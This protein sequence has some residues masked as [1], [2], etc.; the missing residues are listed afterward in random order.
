MIEFVTMLNARFAEAAP[1]AGEPEE[2]AGATGNRPF[3][4]LISEV[5]AVVAA[6]A[7]VTTAA[8]ALNDWR[9][10]VAPQEIARLAP[11]ST[12]LAGMRPMLD[13]HHA[14]TRACAAQLDALISKLGV[15]RAALDAFLDDCDAITPERAVLVHAR[16]M[17]TIWRQLAHD[18]KGLIAQIEGAS[19]R[20]LPDLYRQN[21]LILSGLL[22]GAANGLKP[23]LDEAGRLFVP[24]LPQ[25]RRAPRRAIL[26][27]CVVHGPLNVQPGFVRDA[28]AGG[29]GLGRVAGLKRGNRIRVDLASGRQLHG[30]VVW[31]SGASAG[32]RFDAPLEPT[33]TLI[34]L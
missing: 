7:V 26:Q 17:Q 13:Y 16:P 10:A 23:C 3:E 5:H 21:T 4:Y 9:A 24:P 31:V 33:D 15:A 29:L 27:N 18:T 32:M 22:T 2:Y 30:V 14:L 6:V 25:R 34:A 11:D 8:N 19:P 12:T 1:S 28:S 20:P